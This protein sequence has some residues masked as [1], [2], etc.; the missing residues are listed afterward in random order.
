M[1]ETGVGVRI[2]RVRVT[3]PR[4]KYQKYTV[5][6]IQKEAICVSSSLPAVRYSGRGAETQLGGFGGGRCCIMALTQSWNKL[7]RPWQ[8]VQ[9]AF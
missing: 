1:D 4:W 6:R 7:K 2:P 9:V 5:T 8:L 3:K